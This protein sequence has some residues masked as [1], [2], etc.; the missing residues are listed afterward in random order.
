MEDED[1][2]LVFISSIKGLLIALETINRYMFV[3]KVEYFFLK[4]SSIFYKG[5]ENKNY[6]IKEMG[7][8]IQY[9]KEMKHKI[10]TYDFVPFA[11]ELVIAEEKVIK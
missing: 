2:K 6:I 7:H 5:N 3:T 10:L 9:L 8:S 11:R 1:K 4:L